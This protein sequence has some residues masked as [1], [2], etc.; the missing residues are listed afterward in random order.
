MRIVFLAGLLMTLFLGGCRQ[1]Q[2]EILQVDGVFAG[3]AGKKI[4]LAE[5][6]FQE[7]ERRVIDSATL[8]S[9]GKFNLSAIQQQE[10]IYQLLI[11]DGPGILLI[12]DT[13]RLV[14]KAHIDSLNLYTV[15]HSQASLSIKKLFEKMMGLDEQ[16][17]K[18]T[19]ALDSVEK[20]KKMPD[21]L[22]A[23]IRQMK[24]QA[25][26]AMTDF[27]TTYLAMEQ[28]PTAKWY[29]LGLAMHYLDKKRWALEL[30]K[31]V[32]A[33]PRHVGLNLLKSKLAGSLQ[34]ETMGQEWMGKNLPDM[35]LTD[36]SGKAV[37][38]SQFRGKWLFIDFWASWCAPCRQQNP[39]LR[40]VYQQFKNKPFRMLGV[41][42]DKERDAWTKA[43]RADSL[44]WVQ[45][46]DLKQWESNAIKQYGFNA[47]P[48]NFLLDTSGKVVAVN[49]KEPA[50]SEMLK[51]NL[52]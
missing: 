45:V 52:P 50:L 23:P 38:V 9:T 39:Q 36:T 15:Q 2:T 5:L 12:N 6:P 51:K 4:L 28:N 10:G 14:I 40:T 7:R 19:R 21:S 30:E 31:A 33:N 34:L 35:T 47:I 25:D 27:F 11:E 43:I 1:Q 16:M 46:S 26:K 42:L 44:P 8:D 41:S 3:A 18:A 32:A 20:D 13:N 48:F 22:K 24:T 37:S 29:G 49:I 17:A